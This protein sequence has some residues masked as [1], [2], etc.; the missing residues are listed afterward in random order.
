MEQT[1]S[2]QRLRAF[3][4]SSLIAFEERRWNAIVP[5]VLTLD[6]APNIVVIFKVTKGFDMSPDDRHVLE[7]F[8]RNLRL[9]YP[10]ALVWAFGSRARGD[11]RPE[12]DFDVC[13]VLSNASPENRSAVRSLAWETAFEH[14]LLLNVVVFAASDFE[15]G[16]VSESSLVKSVLAEGVAA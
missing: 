15:R 8:A 4:H 5:E 2:R 12:S 13:V 9:R 16:P 14:C 11:N 6:T 7:E 10:E 3:H 1:K